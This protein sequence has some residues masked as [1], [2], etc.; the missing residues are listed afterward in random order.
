MPNPWSFDEPFRIAPGDPEADAIAVQH[1]TA[2]DGAPLLPDLL[3]DH[4]APHPHVAGPGGDDQVAVA[5]D[6]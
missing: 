6:L 5:V 3:I 4:R 1:V 2:F